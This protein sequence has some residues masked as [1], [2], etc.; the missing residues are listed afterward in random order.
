MNQSPIDYFLGLPAGTML[1]HDT[2]GKHIKVFE[3]EQL[4][5]YGTD[6][7]S[8]HDGAIRHASHLFEG[9]TQLGEF[10]NTVR[11]LHPEKLPDPVGTPDWLQR[12]GKQIDNSGGTPLIPQGW[13]EGVQKDIEG[14][15]V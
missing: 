13:S 5:L 14:R 4:H 11:I 9:I 8:C 1:I 10:F 15:C 3:C 7:V 6:I 12:L 2:L